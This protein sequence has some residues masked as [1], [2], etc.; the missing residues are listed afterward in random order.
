MAPGLELLQAKLQVLHRSRQKH[1]R[2]VQGFRQCLPAAANV[3]ACNLL[4]LYTDLTPMISPYLLIKQ[5]IS[6]RHVQ[7][8]SGLRE[9]GE[10]S[11]RNAQNCTGESFT[12]TPSYST[13]GHVGI[14]D[15]S[16]TNPLDSTVCG[17]PWFV[18]LS[19]CKCQCDHLRTCIGCV[20]VT[21][22][23]VSRLPSM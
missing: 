14:V 7:L 6:C 17:N 1:W 5:I 11:G 8:V 15:S 20:C 3:V 10:L 13:E 4:V 19:A 16:G 23:C 22:K 2:R 12:H 9:C 18:P 21:H